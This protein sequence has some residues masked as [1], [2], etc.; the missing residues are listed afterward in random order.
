VS[1]RG[2]RSIWQWAAAAVLVFALLGGWQLWQ[3]RQATESSY[4]SLLAAAQQVEAMKEVTNTSATIHLVTL[5]D[6]SSVLLR[7]NSRLAFPTRF[8]GRNRTVYLK[9]D[10]FFEVAKNPE[11]PF[12]VTTAHLVTKVLGTSFEV[13][14]RAE[15]PNVVVTVKTG[16]VSVY[17]RESEQA[18]LEAQTR[19]LEGF[20]L[21][22]NQQATYRFK[23]QKLLRSLVP[24]PALQPGAARKATF[25][26]AETPIRKVFSDIEQAYNV[27]IVY[28]EATLG[29]CPIT[30]SLNDEPLFEKLNLICKAV[31]ANYE[32]LD[33]QLVVTGAGC[34]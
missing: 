26:Y 33:T 18:Q 16:R 4:E 19:K 13:Q 23:D 25:E 34:Q 10:A 20:V 32:V 17:P 1:S 30:A 11:H 22:P 27:D 12:F 3:A 15:A 2:Q 14:A 28:D 8:T 21:A 7:P 31:R 9:G 29:N 5:P 6:G 24:Q